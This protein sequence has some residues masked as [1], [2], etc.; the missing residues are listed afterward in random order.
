MN[1]TP[2]I[3]LRKPANTASVDFALDVEEVHL[4]SET[5]E[6]FLFSSQNH[7]FYTRAYSLGKK[8][9]QFQC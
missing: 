1:Q 4:P 5:F 3:L 7:L 8:G 9:F 6:S 2:Q